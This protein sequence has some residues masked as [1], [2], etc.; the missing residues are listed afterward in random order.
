M[1]WTDWGTPA[2]IE[3]ASMCGSNRTVL[4]NTNLQWPNALTIDYANQIL[5]WLDAGLDRL[6]RS[7]TDG[8]GRTL[9]YTFNNYHPFGLTFYD[10]GLFWTDWALKAVLGYNVTENSTV[11]VIFG[12]L[13]L[14]PMSI[15][16]ACAS[17]QINGKLKPTACVSK[18]NRVIV[19]TL[20]C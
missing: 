18:L 9:L 13:I 2:T 12:D 14:D 19:T 5:Y 4:H 10:G 6:E 8:S 15:T 11:N 16:A 7:N 17:R 1:Y 3:R 20:R